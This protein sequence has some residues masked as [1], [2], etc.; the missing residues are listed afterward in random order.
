MA[1]TLRVS[2]I[3]SDIEDDDD[4]ADQDEEDSQDV[5][6]SV[7][8]LDE[9]DD[10]PITPAEKQLISATIKRVECAISPFFYA[11]LKHHPV[12]IIIDTGAT[13]SVVSKKFLRP[14]Q[15]PGTTFDDL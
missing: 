14:P 3:S 9:S 1:K 6:I 4:E 10:T 2:T 7:I 11:F 12:H 5:A 8:Q 15:N 13:S